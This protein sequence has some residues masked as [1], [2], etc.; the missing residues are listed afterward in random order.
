MSSKMAGVK[1]RHLGLFGAGKALVGRLVLGFFF[2][3]SNQGSVR[4]R[5]GEERQA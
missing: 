1:F 4:L 3:T 2:K 5:Q